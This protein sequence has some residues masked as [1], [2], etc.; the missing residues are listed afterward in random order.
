MIRSHCC[1]GDS[2]QKHPHAP[3]QSHK[4]NRKPSL[5]LFRISIDFLSWVLFVCLFIASGF[6][7][8]VVE[9]DDGEHARDLLRRFNVMLFTNFCSVFKCG[10]V[11][12]FV[13][14]FWFSYRKEWRGWSLKPRRKVRLFLRLLIV[15]IVPFETLDFELVLA[16]FFTEAASQVA[17]GY[18]GLSSS[19]RSFGVRKGGSSSSHQGS[20]STGML[21]ADKSFFLIVE[22]EMFRMYRSEKNHVCT[23]GGTFPSETREEKEYREPWVCHVI[24]VSMFLVSCY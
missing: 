13:A 24:T 18:S 11:V 12:L 21:F 10:L 2:S 9:D 3:W 16:S 14:Q 20:P 4:S 23:T 7:S 5:L 15:E 8:E 17:F 19:V 1:S 22:N 6:R